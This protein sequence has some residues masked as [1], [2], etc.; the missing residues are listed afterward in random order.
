MSELLVMGRQAIR[1]LQ[2]VRW[3]L[4]QMDSAVRIV[5]IRLVEGRQR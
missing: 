4:P 2:I 5:W 3:F 1:M